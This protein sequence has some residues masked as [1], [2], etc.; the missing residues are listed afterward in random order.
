MASL[1][2]LGRASRALAVGLVAL[3]GWADAQG[4]LDFVMFDAIDYFPWTE[5]PSLREHR[6][7]SAPTSPPSDARSAKSASGPEEVP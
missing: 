3:A 5:E 2:R 1:T 4:L 6:A 7:T